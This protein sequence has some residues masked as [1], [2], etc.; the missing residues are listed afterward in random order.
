[1]TSIILGF[2]MLY[3]LIASAACSVE[4]AKQGGAANS[5]MLLSVLV[6]YG[7]EWIRFV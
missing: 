3:M 5:V 2:L 4:A 6:T 1:M 7:R